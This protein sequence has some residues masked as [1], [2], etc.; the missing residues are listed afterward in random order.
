MTPDMSQGLHQGKW[1]F[2]GAFTVPSMKKIFR[3]ELTSRVGFR[4]RQQESQV[5]SPGLNAPNSVHGTVV[6]ALD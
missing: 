6:K 4:F 1:L 5:F 3:E 2:N